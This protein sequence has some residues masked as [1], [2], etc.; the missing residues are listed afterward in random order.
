M[1]TT[2]FK[3]IV[4]AIVLGFAWFLVGLIVAAFPL[5][6]AVTTLVVGVLLAFAFLIWVLRAFDIKFN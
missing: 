3:A 5:I 1:L 4:L 6:P 2:I